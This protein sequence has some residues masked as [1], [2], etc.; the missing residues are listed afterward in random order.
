MSIVKQPTNN[1]M[2]QGAPQ[3]VP[4]NPSV[5]CGQNMQQFVIPAM[6][7]LIMFIQEQATNSEIRAAL[8][9][10]M[11][12]N[13]YNNNYFMELL[14][15][16]VSYCEALIIQNPNINTAVEFP[17][18]CKL[19]V[20]FHVSAEVYRDERLQQL[21]TQQQA[22][23]IQGMYAK[24]KEVG[25][26]VLKTLSG[27][28]NQGFANQGFAGLADRGGGGFGN[29][30]Q[31]QNNQSSGFGFAPAAGATGGFQ[32]R[33]GSGGSSTAAAT[34]SAPLWGTKP[35]AAAAPARVTPPAKVEQPVMPKSPAEGDQIQASPDIDP[36]EYLD[37]HPY[38]WDA[39]TQVPFYRRRGTTW[40]NFIADKD[41]EKVKYELHENQHLLKP[42]TAVPSVVLQL[43]S[44]NKAQDAVIK[45]AVEKLTGTHYELEF[46]KDMTFDVLRIPDYIPNGGNYHDSVVSYCLGNDND[47][48]LETM[49]FIAT[50]VQFEGYTFGEQLCALLR[51]VANSTT[52]VKMA[53]AMHSLQK[54]MA[55]YNWS[56]IDRRM[57]DHLNEWL[58]RQSVHAPAVLSFTDNVKSL[59]SELAQEFPDILEALNTT[60]LEEIANTTLSLDNAK[61]FAEIMEMEEV[62]S[63][64]LAIYE[65]VALVPIVASQCDISVGGNLSLITKQALPELH[66]FIERT[67]LFADKRTRYVKIITLDNCVM[68]IYKGNAKSV[69]LC[70]DTNDFSS[71]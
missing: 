47:V 67:Q 38:A 35:Q 71:I 6:G 64:R 21:C 50:F 51:N 40:I 34:T 42:R 43:A 13:G 3:N 4:F 56:T 46:F 55:L 22:H 12:T 2:F 18:V 16:T 24:Y 66:A 57:T 30:N 19:M 33:R 63:E 29:R 11:V 7:H 59:C 26:S 37:V 70:S 69:Y 68:W 45:A 41:D 14:Q 32:S 58:Y 49:C 61:V 65:T 60:F 44:K 52:V 15:E 39:K 8:F 9:W 54:D 48:D 36:S 53:E 5:D 27:Q 25:A 1:D 31:S 62:G 23:D 10:R 28:R 17:E 20:N